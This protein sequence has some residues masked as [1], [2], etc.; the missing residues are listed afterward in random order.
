MNSYLNFTEM[1]QEP[2]KKTKQWY[3]SAGGDVLGYIIFF[4]HWRKYI[5]K[6][7]HANVLFDNKCLLE[8]VEF[9]DKVNAERQK[10]L[11]ERKEKGE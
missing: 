5:F 9:L 11:K 10:E 6:P 3:I 1:T 4:N 2:R 7:E 8:I